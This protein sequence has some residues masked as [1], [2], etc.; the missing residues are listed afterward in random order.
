M[1]ERYEII[2]AGSGGQGLVVCGIL[3]AEAAVVEGK[4]VVQTQ[5]YG[6][7]SRGGFSKSEV[8]ISSQEIIF[9]QVENPDAVLV[10]TEQAM[11]RYASL[12][13]RV[14]LFY[15]TALVKAPSRENAYGFPFTTIATELGHTGVANIIALGAMASIIGMVRTES[16]E[17]V[18]KRRFSGQLAETNLKALQA[19]ID[20]AARSGGEI[21]A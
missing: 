2:F 20:L 1:K 9:Q 8:I 11:S 5:S 13:P 17:K 12:Y 21:H 19:G 10:L 3:L 16:L 4:N 6:I 7:A 14:P 18:L 15:D